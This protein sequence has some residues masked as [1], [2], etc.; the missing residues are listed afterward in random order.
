MRKNEKKAVQRTVSEWD[1]SYTC[2]GCGKKISPDDWAGD[3]AHELTVHLDQ[4]QCVNFF[5]QRDYCPD[6][7]DPVWRTINELL[8][9]D[10]AKER[11]REYE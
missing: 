6:C 3:Y 4:D 10:P 2:D 5:R 11:D 7:L 9:A 8:N 1:T